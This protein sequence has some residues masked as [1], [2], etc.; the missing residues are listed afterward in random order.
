MASKVG[1][2]FPRKGLISEEYLTV[3]GGHPEDS[4]RLR[5]IKHFQMKYLHF[6]GH[7]VC[8]LT[9]LWL[10]IFQKSEKIL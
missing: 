2:Y 4:H 3:Q 1:Q 7:W 9:S 6:A 10:Y 8:N 5:E